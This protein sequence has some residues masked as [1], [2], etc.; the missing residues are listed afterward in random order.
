[1][2]ARKHMR[3]SKCMGETLFALHVRRLLRLLQLLRLLRLLR[4]QLLAQ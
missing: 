1:M 2:H 4:S 3:M